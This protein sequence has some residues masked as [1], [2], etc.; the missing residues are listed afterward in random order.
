L[1]KLDA[2]EKGDKNKFS[3]FSESTLELAEAG[4]VTAKVGEYLSFST[5]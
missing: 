2:L 3:K 1:G 4:N 5:Y